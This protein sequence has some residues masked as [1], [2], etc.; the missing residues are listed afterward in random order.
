MGWI[1]STTSP[2]DRQADS[3]LDDMV[4]VNLLALFLGGMAT[5]DRTGSETAAVENW[6]C[7]LEN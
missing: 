1:V 3:G 6:R 7:G 5:V 2:S 4:G